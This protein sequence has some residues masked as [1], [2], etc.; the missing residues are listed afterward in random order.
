MIYLGASWAVMEATEQIVD[1]YLL[2]EW[3]YPAALILLLIGLPIVLATAFVREDVDAVK[4]VTAVAAS[5]L[6]EGTTRE[7]ASGAAASRGR[8]PVTRLLTWPKAILGGV[9]AFTV[10]G[11]M[12]AYIVVRGSA[13]VTEAYGAAG[14]AFEERA[15]IVVADVESNEGADDV[16]LA[17]QTALTLDLQQSTFV[18]VY[19]R[20]ELAGVLGR[21]GL[22]D[23]IPLDEELALEVAERQGL[24]AVLV[25]SVSRLGS[26]YVFGARVLQPVDGNELIVVRIAARENRLIDGVETLSRGVRSRLG[27]ERVLIRRSKPLPEVTTSSLEALKRFAQARAANE[28]FGDFDRAVKLADEAIRLDSSFAAAY[29]MAAVAH[30]NAGRFAEGRKYSRHAYELRQRLPDRERLYTEAWYHWA[31]LLDPRRTVETYELLLSQ[32][33]DEARA[34]NNLGVM[35]GLYLGDY[36]RNYEAFRRGVD[37]S[38]S[39]LQL[40]NAISSAVFNGHAEAADSLIRRAEEEGY[41]LVYLEGQI[42]RSFVQAN[43]KAVDAL[44][45]SLL[46]E[47]VSTGKRAYNQ[48]YCGSIDA[49]R[50][51]LRRGIGRLEEAGRYFAETGQYTNLSVTVN[52]IVLS[53]EM[54]RREAAAQAR[55]ETMLDRFPPDSIGEPDRFLVRTE[56]VVLA[57]LLESPELQDRIESA[58]P[59]F[60]D[61][62]HWLGR[63]GAGLSGAAAALE[64][65]DPALAV[66]SLRAGTASGYKPFYWLPL[67]HLLFGLAFDG[68]GQVDSAVVHLETAA[69]PRN[70]FGSTF[71]LG[72]FH[73][74]AA[75]RRLAELEES[76]GNTEAAIRHYQSFLKLWSD[77]D[78]ELRDQV[79]AAR[80]ALARLS[81]A[82]R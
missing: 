35:S 31:V 22:P 21:M 62:T 69:E 17:V 54:R 8:R 79:D 18:N 42:D 24:A 9:L 75:L 76:R 51:R 65:G 5:G 59:P 1:R 48:L 44:C 45:D 40:G 14:D 49:A 72:R 39:P 41:R 11:L 19:G 10:L 70:N 36:E 25:G 29:G 81:G 67:T 2:P 3:V 26:D 56:L 38:P 28:V 73:L 34:I 66:E 33:P 27:E 20:R 61:S 43:W 16:R 64:R 46:A 13:R 77:A 82:E 78:P 80:R 53:E 63:Y 60:L 68:L 37:L 50:G 7:E 12:S 58:Y 71:A 57:A 32:Y 15:W 52:G 47:S 74:P 6:P 55:L 30:D 23:T 4:A